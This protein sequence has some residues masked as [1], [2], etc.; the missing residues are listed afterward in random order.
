MANYILTNTSLQVEQVVSQNYCRLTGNF[1]GPLSANSASN[2]GFLIQNGN[3]QSGLF[4]GNTC[5]IFSRNVLDFSQY[6]ENVLFKIPSSTYGF[7][8]SGGNTNQVLNFNTAG[9]LSVGS[10]GDT[11]YIGLQVINSNPSIILKD[12]DAA[13]NNQ[14]IAFRSSGNS[15]ITCLFNNPSVTINALSTQATQF[16]FNNALILNNFGSTNTAILSGGYLTLNSGSC[17]NNTYNLSVGGSGFFTNGILSQTIQGNA[18]CFSGMNLRN[19]TNFLNFY[20]QSNVGSN[21]LNFYNV[22]NGLQGTILSD[23]TTVDGSSKIDFFTTPSGL[24]SSLDRKQL[25]LR[26]CGNANVNFYGNISGQTGFYNSYLQAN[27]FRNSGSKTF[28]NTGSNGFHC[29]LLNN[30]ANIYSY[31]ASDNCV[32][33]HIW[34]VS[35]NNIAMC[36]DRSGNASVTGSIFSH[37]GICSTGSLCISN[38]NLDSCI[39]SRCVLISGNN[40]SCNILLYGNVCNLGSFENNSTSSAKFMGICTTGN[41][42]SVISGLFRT[43]SNICSTGNIC[44]LGCI[45]TSSSGIFNQGVCSNSYISAQSCGVFGSMICVSGKTLKSCFCNS[46]DVC[47]SVNANNTAKAWGIY[48]LNNTFT[49]TLTGLNIKSINIYQNATPLV[50]AYGICFNTAVTYPFVVNFNVYS[51]GNALITGNN[52]N[53]QGGQSL[54]FSGTSAT[55]VHLGNSNSTVNYPFSIQFYALSGKRASDNTFAAYTA[56]VSYSEIYF[57]LANQ[58]GPT[59]AYSDLTKT[60]ANGII[61]FSIFGQ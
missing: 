58:K 34:Y 41:V 4:V 27:E 19:S 49:P 55:N 28:L 47:G 36:L 60:N 32:T 14:S 1:V 61:H 20:N 21:G 3:K 17:L 39:R 30:S 53:I 15:F 6:S 57:N 22:Y 40:N 51:S 37:S 31:V 44:S 59:T 9:T 35:G 38:Q 13:T 52:S 54:G 26:I 7:Y 50:Y 11:N 10:S 16:S 43:C 8:I 24:F 56:G 2:C 5:Y 33:N 48:G 25:A 42:E 46:V 18:G 29:F 23:Q 12:T 45:Q